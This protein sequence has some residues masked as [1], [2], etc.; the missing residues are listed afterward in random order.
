MKWS[1]FECNFTCINLSDKYH[2]L[3]DFR[4]VQY[5]KQLCTHWWKKY[6]IYKICIYTVYFQMKVWCCADPAPLKFIIQ[7][8]EYTVWKTK[9]NITKILFTLSQTV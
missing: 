9:Y 5:N 6:Y 3:L 4:N 8:C 1:P 7:M 2:Y